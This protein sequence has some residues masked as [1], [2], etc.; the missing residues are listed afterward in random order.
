[1]DTQPAVVLYIN[2][3][4][5][6]EKLPEML[7]DLCH[8]INILRPENLLLC[9]PGN[10]ALEKPKSFAEVVGLIEQVRFL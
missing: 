6:N 9:S 3:E 8:E 7:E 10:L 1:M 5:S 4:I 2:F